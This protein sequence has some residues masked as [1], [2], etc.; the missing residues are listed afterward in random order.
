M[1]V[2]IAPDYQTLLL[3]RTLSGL[4]LG[5]YPP[6]L[7]AYSIEVKRKLN[8]F[9]SYGS[10]GWGGGILILGFVAQFMGVRWVFAVSSL[11]YFVGFLFALTLNQG[12]FHKVTIPAFPVAI[13]KKNMSLYAAI[14]IRHSG[15]VMI[16][17]FWP[18][19]MVQELGLSL[20]EVGFIQ[21]TNMLFQF[22]VMFIFGERLKSSR[23]V[24]LGIVMSSA[25][26][27]SFTLAYD[28]WTLW[29]TQFGLATCWALIYV[30][31][32]RKLDECNVEKAT[33]NGLF[34]SVIAMS[35]ILGPLMS[36]A[37]IQVTDY[38]SIMYMAAVFSLISAVVY[39]ILQRRDQA[40]PDRAACVD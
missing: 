33:A 8:K 27:F 15:A 21:A 36:T 1:T 29:L 20:L 31:S 38:T 13:I 39:V 3:T 28:F 19:Y 35:A 23:S 26:F 17:T 34:T 25:V 9:A 37:L 2:F 16:W 12:G 18:I 40:D 6:A 7:V 24:M 14:L 5:I 11:F 22:V 32:L 10:I 30:G 4:C